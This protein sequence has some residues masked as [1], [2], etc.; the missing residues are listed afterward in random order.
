MIDI[1]KKTSERF[2]AIISQRERQAKSICEH[3][4]ILNALKK[5]KGNLAEKLMIEHVE[6]AKQALLE[7]IN[8]RKNQN[9]DK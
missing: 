9:N 5:K 2:T 4:E 8:S 7:E 1:Y 3:S 6:N